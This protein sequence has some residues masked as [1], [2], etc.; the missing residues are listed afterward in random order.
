[1]IIRPLT[2]EQEH[3]GGGTGGHQSQL[4]IFF[5]SQVTFFFFLTPLKSD[6]L[7]Q[8]NPLTPRENFF[9]NQA[10]IF[11]TA[12]VSENNENLVLQLFFYICALLIY[13]GKHKICFHIF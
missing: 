11:R 4:V 1:L 2:F 8:F 13:R 9:Y 5:R 10:E 3:E 6:N 12:S 7:G